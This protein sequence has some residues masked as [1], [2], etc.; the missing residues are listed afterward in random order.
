MK[1]KIGD[2]WKEGRK[3]KVQSPGEIF[4]CNTKENA[5]RV[6]GAIIREE[7]PDD[8]NPDYVFQTIRNSLLLMIINGQIDTKKAA[9]RELRNRGYNEKGKW[10]GVK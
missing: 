3:W 2:V 8:E 4:I 7:L 1:H 5:E 10:V 6:S 9:I